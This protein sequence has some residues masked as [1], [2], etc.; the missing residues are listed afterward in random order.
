MQLAN[1]P[2]FGLLPP[3]KK[4]GPPPSSECFVCLSAVLRDEFR[5]WPVDTES[6]C[7]CCLLAVLRDEFRVFWPVDTESLCLCVSV[8]SVTG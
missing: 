4:V 8:G 2:R 6:V 3:K 7:L 5:V 1:N